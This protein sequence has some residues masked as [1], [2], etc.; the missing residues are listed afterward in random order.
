MLA[1][2]GNSLAHRAYHA[3][4]DT[5]DAV[6]HF[7]TPGFFGMLGPVWSHGPFDAV[8]VAFDSPHNQRKLDFPEYK[9]NRDGRPRA[10]RPPRRS[11]R[12]HV[13]GRLHTVESS[14]APRATTCWRP[15][16]TA[17][18]VRGWRC[19]VLSS[20]RDLTALVDTVR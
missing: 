14:P 9:A 19:A 20:D 13:A 11:C 18:T 12:A 1:V 4:R 2:D 15:S 16:P 8:V 3:I 6:G 10:A 17:C 7:V 5:E